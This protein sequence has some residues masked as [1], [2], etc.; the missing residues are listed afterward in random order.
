MLAA[1]KQ[2]ETD[3]QRIARI[4]A[5]WQLEHDNEMCKQCGCHRHMHEGLDEC[6]VVDCDCPKYVPNVKRAA[7]QIIL[8]EDFDYLVDCAEKLM[9]SETKHTPG[10]LVLLGRGERVELGNFLSAAI[11]QALG[12]ANTANIEQPAESGT[13]EV[14]K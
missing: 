7:I 2:V 10:P 8:T 11:A 14:M 13:P 9:H 4:K 3:E 12:T 1:M 6:R 5:R